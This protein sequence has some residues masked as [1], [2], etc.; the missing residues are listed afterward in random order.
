LDIEHGFTAAIADVNMDWAVV[1]VVKEESISV[2][3]ELS[4]SPNDSQIEPRRAISFALENA[5][6]RVRTYKTHVANQGFAS[7]DT[8]IDAQKL[9]ERSDLIKVIASWSTLPLALRDAVL[10]IV[11]AHEGQ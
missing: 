3:F 8:Q 10:A 5:R 2:L 9:R 11:R 4:A 1:V 7:P 6:C